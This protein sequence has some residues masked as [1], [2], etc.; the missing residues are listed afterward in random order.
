MKGQRE[1]GKNTCNKQENNKPR[2]SLPRCSY[3]LILKTFKPNRVIGQRTRIHN[4]K[5]MKELLHIN[6][7]ICYY[8]YK[9]Q[10]EV[11]LL[12]I[13][14]A[15]IKIFYVYTQKMHRQERTVWRRR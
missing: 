8:H 10:V 7:K 2:M 3:K 14:L 13:K 4:S 15:N 1:V 12:T 6:I 9:L 11:A 5:K